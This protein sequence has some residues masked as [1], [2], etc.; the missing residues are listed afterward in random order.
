MQMFSTMSMK[1][2]QIL[3][4]LS[5]RLLCAQLLL[6]LLTCMQLSYPTRAGCTNDH[7][8]DALTSI[9]IMFMNVH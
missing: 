9:P 5:V 6:Y 1:V 3:L 4:N 8:T 7:P 2:L